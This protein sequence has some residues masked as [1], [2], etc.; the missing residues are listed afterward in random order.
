MIACDLGVYDAVCIDG[1]FGV[2]GAVFDELALDRLAALDIGAAVAADALCNVDLAAGDNART[3]Y[4][5]VDRDRAGAADLIIL[6]H[7]AADENI[8]AKINVADRGIHVACDLQHGTHG[9]AT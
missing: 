2:N 7:I 9:K 5:S 6:R 1:R 8:A 4:K 3:L